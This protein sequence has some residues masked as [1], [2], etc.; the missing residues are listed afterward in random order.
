MDPG[1]LT[2]LW[3]SQDKRRDYCGPSRDQATIAS[4]AKKA[5]GPGSA[6]AHTDANDLARQESSRHLDI[7]VAGEV[8]GLAALESPESRKPTRR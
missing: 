5:I 4:N 3:P 7:N 1:P 8:S 6:C 2:T